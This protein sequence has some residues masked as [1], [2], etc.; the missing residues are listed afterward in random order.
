LLPACSRRWRDLH[1]G[2]D[3]AGEQSQIIARE[4]AVLFVPEITRLV[5]EKQLSAPD[6][7]KENGIVGRVEEKE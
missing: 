6:H 4:G 3:R 2:P 5:P 7:F 1:N